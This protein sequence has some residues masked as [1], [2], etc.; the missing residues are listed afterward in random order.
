MLGVCLS[1]F[2][3][4]TN[5]HKQMNTHTPCYMLG[6]TDKQALLWF[7]HRVFKMVAALRRG[8]TLSV[9]SSFIYPLS[10]HPLPT[11]LLPIQ[12]IIWKSMP[13][14]DND[15]IIFELSQLFWFVYWIL[16]HQLPNTPGWHGFILWCY[17]KS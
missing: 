13:W 16:C 9:P 11:F 5:T 3:V 10:Y 4:N 12:K 6:H 17:Q 15:R 14:Q 1:S 8:R 7:L 2:S